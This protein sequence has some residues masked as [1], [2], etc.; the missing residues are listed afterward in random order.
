MANF[1]A[2]RCTETANF[3]NRIGREVIV[4]HEIGVGQTVQAI[5]HLL[6]IARAQCGGA[7]CLRFTAGKQRRTVR[8]RQET[9]HA[10]NRAD[11]RGGTAI[12]TA[13]IFQDCAAND[14]RF[15]L[16]HDLVG[17][18]LRLRCFTCEMR[19][20]RRAGDIQRI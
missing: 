12:D 8:T 13:A 17:G 15:Q 18:H 19:L 16:F 5:D 14:F 2:A 6:A 10:F 7:D 4:Q 11:L 3:A 1:A 9:D 20:G